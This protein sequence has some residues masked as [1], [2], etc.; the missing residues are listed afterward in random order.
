[1]SV[2]V[3]KHGNSLSIRI[4]AQIARTTGLRAGDLVSVRLLDSG[5]IRVRPLAGV[6][7]ADPASDR[8][9]C[10]PEAAKQEQQW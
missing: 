8:E 6:V 7:P 5:D 1:M 4:G 9:G 2:K 10:A 3:C